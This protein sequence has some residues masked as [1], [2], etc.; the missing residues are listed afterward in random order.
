M[1][2]KSITN[3]NPE[4]VPR[5][6][7]NGNRLATLDGALMRFCLFSRKVNSFTGKQF[8]KLFIRYHQNSLDFNSKSKK[9]ELV[10]NKIFETKNFL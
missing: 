3:Q 6:M 9:L 2:V 5:T 10:T 7:T 8:S 1:F 4:E